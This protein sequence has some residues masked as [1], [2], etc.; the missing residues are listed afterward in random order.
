ML[1]GFTVNRGSPD[2]MGFVSLLSF[3]GKQVWFHSTWCDPICTWTVKEKLMFP[4]FLVRLWP[5]FILIYSP[6][7]ANDERVYLLTAL[8]HFQSF[9]II[10]GTA[11]KDPLEMCSGSPVHSLSDVFAVS[12]F[13]Q[14]V[15]HFPQNRKWPGGQRVQKCSLKQEWHSSLHPADQQKQQQ[16]ILFI[17]F[18]I[19]DCGET[20]TAY[21]CRCWC[22]GSAFHKNP[23]GKRRGRRPSAASHR[24]PGGRTGE[25]YRKD[26]H[27]RPSTRCNQMDRVY[28]QKS[29]LW[30]KETLS[31]LRWYSSFTNASSKVLF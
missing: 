29:Y 25:V 1:T 10:F 21:C 14:L 31:A 16:L 9:F 2:L 23:W 15:S 7:A 19:I 12:P 11:V 18:G 30:I 28:S 3:H 6:A 22:V 27:S 20:Y 24:S 5:K 13:G 4:H 26:S 17:I 8:Q